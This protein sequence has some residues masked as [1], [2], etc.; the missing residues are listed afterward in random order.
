MSSHTNRN[1]II[2]YILLVGLPIVGLLGVLRSGRKLSAPISVDGL[3]HLQIDPARLASLPCGNALASS[4]D[5]A[6][7]ISQSGTNF[8]LTLANGPKAT[9]EGQLNG[10]ALK[11]SIAPAPEWSA[12]AGCGNDRGLALVATVDPKSEPKSLVGTLS[13]NNCP[14]CEAVEIRAVKQNPAKRI[15]H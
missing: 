13:V 9:A 11:A 10:T 7:A 1:F 15:G 14:S 5:T 3:W 12:Q 2:A 8:T 6:L 4:P